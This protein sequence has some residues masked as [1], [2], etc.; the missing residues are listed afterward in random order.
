M[1]PFSLPPIPAVVLA[2]LSIQGGAAFA[3]TLFPVLG[4]FGTTTL[5][6]SLAALLLLAVLRPN[7]R[8][9][10]RADWLA[11]LP[12]GV[13]L[14]LMNLAF[15]AA[16]Q[17]LPLGLAVTFEF[18]GP[19][20]LA[21]FMSRKP[22]DFVWVALAGLGIVLIAPHGGQLGQAGQAAPLHLGGVA[23]ALLAGA[24]WVV[25]ILAGGAMGRRVS[26]TAGVVAGM[27]VAAVISLPLGIL[28]SGSKLL[29][30]PLLLACLGVALLSSALPYTLEMRALRALPANVFGVLMSLEP[31]IAALSGLLFLGEHLTPQQ[32]LALL[33]VVGASAGIS[34]TGRGAAHTEPEPVN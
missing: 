31:A 14:G 28:Q 15:Y 22:L 32:W 27:L 21:L 20:L 10:S 12:Y 7:L 24:F 8:Q 13:S 19:L 4:P 3:K 25:Y 1:R 29:H 23:L 16:V 5:R 26:G 9:L 34:L 6:V 11:V 2:M 17:H 30:P 18:V 33:C